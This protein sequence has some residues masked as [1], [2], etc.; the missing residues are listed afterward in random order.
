MM[1]AHSL[2]RP[3]V[4]VALVLLC[5][6]VASC[7]RGQGWRLKDIS[8]L[9]PELAFTLTDDE[10]R[11]VTADDYRGKIA[12]LFLGYTHCP[13]ACPTTLATLAAAINAS[14]VGAA[15]FRVLFVTVDP[16]R[17][18]RERMH[19]YVNAFGRE[20]TG[21]RGTN[22]QLEDIARRYRVAFSTT[23]PDAR[24]NY[25]VNHSSAVFIFDELGRARLLVLPG[26]S[27]EAITGDIRK[28]AAIR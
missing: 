8:G 25:E 16:K 4:V 21:L 23:P 5:A 28:L 12:L 1:S 9:V 27:L 20:F 10:G 17:D 14:G 6:F 15:K 2:K 18:T 22:R 7:T 3:T 26:D 13:D 11:T 24:G 19:E